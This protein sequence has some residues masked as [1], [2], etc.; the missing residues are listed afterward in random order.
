MK[1]SEHLRDASRPLTEGEGQQ[2]GSIAE[3]S[4][5]RAA[6]IRRRILA[7]AYHTTEMA[8]RVA[9]RILERGDVLVGAG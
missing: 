1:L 4:P 7:G 9:R 8:E 3:L 6:E 2:P 5:Q